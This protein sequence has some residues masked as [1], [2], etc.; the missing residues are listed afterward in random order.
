MRASPWCDQTLQVCFWSLLGSKLQDSA[1][2][3][4]A[5]LCPRLAGTSEGLLGQKGELC[6]AEID[7]P[8]ASTEQNQFVSH[9]WATQ[10]WTNGTNR[11]ERRRVLAEPVA[12][13]LLDERKNQVSRN[14]P[15]PHQMAGRR[16][17]LQWA[18]ALEIKLI[19]PGSFSSQIARDQDPGGFSC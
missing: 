9:V 10:T 13:C 11:C 16:V 8:A 14:Q 7:S 12:P 2:A 3:P 1:S 18:K 6:S 17:T 5:V 19:I 4:L 15:I